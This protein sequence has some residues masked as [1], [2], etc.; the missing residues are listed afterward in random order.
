MYEVIIYPVGLLRELKQ[1]RMG[2]RTHQKG[3]VKQFFRHMT[4][5]F[6]MAAKGEWRA[7]KSFFNGYLAEPNPWPAEITGLQRCG[8]AWWPTAARRDLDRRIRMALLWADQD[9]A[10]HPRP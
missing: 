9:R 8:S 10:G 4:Y 6:R 7:A 1:L 5:P 2:I 3:C